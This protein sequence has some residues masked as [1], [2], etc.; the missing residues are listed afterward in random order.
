[1]DDDWFYTTTTVTE[2]C[3]T[4]PSTVLKADGEPFQLERKKEPI[5]FV[6]RPSK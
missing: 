4:R 6:L 1:M 2:Q 5:G 3:P